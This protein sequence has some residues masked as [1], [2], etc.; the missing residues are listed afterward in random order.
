[1]HDVRVGDLFGVGREPDDPAMGQEEEGLMRRQARTHRP[2]NERL[3]WSNSIGG[4][5]VCGDYHARI[6]SAHA[7]ISKCLFGKAATQVCSLSESARGWGVK[8]I[9]V[10]YRLNG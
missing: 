1:M 10:P 3:S 6:L 2:R 4:Q 8:L 5:P 9:H 7:P